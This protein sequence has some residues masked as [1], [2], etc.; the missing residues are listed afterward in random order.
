MVSYSVGGAPGGG[1]L[2]SLLIKTGNSYSPGSQMLAF[3]LV[4]FV[5]TQS[6]FYFNF[7]RALKECNE[8]EQKSVL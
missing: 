2:T 3:Y 8:L 6:L 1:P 5:K 4:S 7:G